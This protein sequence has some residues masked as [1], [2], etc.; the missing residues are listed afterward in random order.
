M[1]SARPPGQQLPEGMAFIG[2]IETAAKMLERTML[3]A[4]AGRGTVTAILQVE[5]DTHYPEALPWFRLLL[6]SIYPPATMLLVFA[7]KPAG[8]LP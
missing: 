1:V 2:S 3:D 8:D 6:L 5:S 7:G 4:A